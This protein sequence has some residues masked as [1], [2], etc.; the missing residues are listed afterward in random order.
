MKK[1]LVSFVVLLLLL[2]ACK[3]TD[4]GPAYLYVIVN[5]GSHFTGQQYYNLVSANAS[6]GNGQSYQVQVSNVSKAIDTIQVTLGITGGSTTVVPNTY[7]VSVE[8][9]IVSGGNP[10]PPVYRASTTS[11][12]TAGQ[13]QYVTLSTN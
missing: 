2:P 12:V 8:S 13:T 7:A 6:N 10:V 4:N 9:Y 11:I 1:I 5:N 3:K